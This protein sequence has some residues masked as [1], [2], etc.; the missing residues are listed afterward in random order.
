MR[1]DVLEVELRRS[2]ISRRGLH[3]ASRSLNFASPVRERGEI[4]ETSR[5]DYLNR[6]PLAARPSSSNRDLAQEV[7]IHEQRHHPG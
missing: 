6:S 7:S 2:A 1:E 4:M 3:F 5:D